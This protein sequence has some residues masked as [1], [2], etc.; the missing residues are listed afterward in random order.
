[1]ARVEA[2][3]TPFGQRVFF[4]LIDGRHAVEVA[5]AT[6][7]GSIVHSPG[8]ESARIVHGKLQALHLH[9]KVHRSLIQL[10]GH[11]ARSLTQQL[12]DPLAQGNLLDDFDQRLLVAPGQFDAA[13][14]FLG[15]QSLFVALHR[16]G[17]G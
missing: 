12:A 5:A 13:R 10:L 4:V 2:G 14:V 7:T 11:S 15:D 1:M 3:Q 6:R 8:E 16:K 9:G 17:D